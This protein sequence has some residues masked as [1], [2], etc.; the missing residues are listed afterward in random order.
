MRSIV[1]RTGYCGAAGRG[2]LTPPSSTAVKFVLDLRVRYRVLSLV[3]CNAFS[4]AVCRDMVMGHGR[5]KYDR[6]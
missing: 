4:L 3:L 2:R 6:Y 5:N 1:V